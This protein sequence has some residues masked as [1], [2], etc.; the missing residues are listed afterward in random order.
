M[1]LPEEIDWV[2]SL[3]GVNLDSIAS[4]RTRD[5]VLHSLPTD[6]PPQ[7]GSIHPYVGLSDRTDD[8]VEGNVRVLVFDSQVEPYKDA[9]DDGVWTVVIPITEI[10]AVHCTGV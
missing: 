6:T 3:Y 9:D 7:P 4:V 8:A 10:T 1:T 2:H 5:G